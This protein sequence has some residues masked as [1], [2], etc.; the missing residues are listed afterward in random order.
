[1]PK[2]K[3]S[4]VVHLTQVTKKTRDHKERLFDNIRECIPQYQH[5]FVFGIDNMR[6]T[7]L[8][9]VRQELSDSRLF[10]GKTKLM[11]RALGH[12]PE[13]SYADN[14]YRLTPYLKGTVGLLFTNRGPAEL[15]PY[16]E[17][18]AG[19]KVDFARAGATSPRDFIVPYGTVYATAG[20]VPPEH[21]VPIGHTLE[22]E[23]RRLG[24]PVRMVKGRVVLEEPPQGGDAG[25]GYVVC[26]EGDVL[27]S[28]QTRLL[29]LFGVCL[30]EFKIDVL[31]Y[32]TAATTEVTP[33][34]PE[35]EGMDGVE[36][37]GGD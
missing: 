21:D 13:D 4:K 25:D 20:E 10:F 19:N 30:S 37:E 2:S 14:I 27:D 36:D 3:R 33:V 35:K 9:E 26:R 17:G 31:A 8:K 28:R 22:P 18:L 15:L 12:S 16:L 23:L 5:C 11:A 24:L 6:N 34:V 7:Y 32:W 1:M 29:K